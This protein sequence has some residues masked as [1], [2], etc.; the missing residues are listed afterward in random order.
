MTDYIL[1]NKDSEIFYA[2]IQI[3]PPKFYGIVE[4]M[5]ISFLIEN[6]DGSEEYPWNIRED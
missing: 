4:G 1:E 5:P 3:E 2:T 6:N